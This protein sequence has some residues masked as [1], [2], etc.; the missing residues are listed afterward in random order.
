MKLL[1]QTS[2]DTSFRAAP[3]TSPDPE[4][5]GALQQF[6][7]RMGHQRGQEDEHHRGLAHSRREAV[8]HHRD[9]QHYAGSP[10]GLP[11]PRCGPG[12]TAGSHLE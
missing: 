6:A 8:E 3:R 2:L 7:D 5:T 1:F 9:G 10:N 11:F 4:R 12:G